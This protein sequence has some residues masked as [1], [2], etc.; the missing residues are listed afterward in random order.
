MYI[1]IH[2]LYSELLWSNHIDWWL[3]DD[4]IDWPYMRHSSALYFREEYDTL[5]KTAPLW[6]ICTMCPG[7]GS[8]RRY[9]ARRHTYRSDFREYRHRTGD[10]SCNKRL[11]V[12]V[13]HAIKYEWRAK[14]EY[15]SVRCW[16]D[17]R[18][19]GADGVRKRPCE[20]NATQRRRK[21]GLIVE[22]AYTHA[23]TCGVVLISVVETKQI[24]GGKIYTSGCWISLEM[25]T[26]P[27]HTIATLGLKSGSKRAAV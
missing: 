19:A 17:I 5:N 27:S 26:T 13:D 18:A 1:Y 12:E 9:Q 16:I 3:A 4:L 20:E 25:M 24:L 21:V 8:P 15:G 14:S 11:S 10:G 2:T 22:H 7:S 6:H 23:Y